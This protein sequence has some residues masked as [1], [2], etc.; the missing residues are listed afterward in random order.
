MSWGTGAIIAVPVSFVV[1]RKARDARRPLPSASRMAMLGGVAKPIFWNMR[2]L[3]LA[4]V[5]LE[6][7]LRSE[8]TGGTGP[9]S[10]RRTLRYRIHPAIKDK[11]KGGEA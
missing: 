10:G 3:H 1:P 11:R 5:V 4:A 2:G 6:D 7:W 9:G 8:A